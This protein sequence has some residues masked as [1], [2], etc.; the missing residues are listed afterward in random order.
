MLIA[1]QALRKSSRPGPF[2]PANNKLRRVALFS[3]LFGNKSLSSDGASTSVI[4]AGCE[5]SGCIRFAGTLVLN[6]KLSGELVSADT[7]LVGDKGAIEADVQVGTAIV[8]G[9]IKGNIVARERIELRGSANI[10]GDVDTPVLVL[11]EGVLLEGRC[12]MKGPGARET[13]K[14]QKRDGVRAIEDGA[15]K[16]QRSHA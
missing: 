13:E 7:L 4:D 9:E 8:N 11:E 3:F 16:Q 10:V 12:R 2:G 6:G 14:V 5:I 15:L 1:T